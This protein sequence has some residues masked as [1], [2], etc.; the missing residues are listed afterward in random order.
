M[1]EGKSEP[2]KL[3]FTA[4]YSIFVS[5][6]PPPQKSVCSLR[7]ASEVVPKPLVEEGDLSS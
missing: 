7:E 3:M 5:R 6:L 2:A 1:H 4:D